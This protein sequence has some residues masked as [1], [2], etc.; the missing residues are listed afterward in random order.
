MQP[1]LQSPE[2]GTNSQTQFLPL[3]SQWM[4]VADVIQFPPALFVTDSAIRHEGG[5]PRR[6][7]AQEGFVQAAVHGDD[8]SGGFAEAL[9]NQ[10]E[11]RLGLISR[12][13]W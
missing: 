2:E 4:L 9:A 10:Q 12:G 13:N 1:T 5:A 11:V 6:D 3:S 7:S 8:L